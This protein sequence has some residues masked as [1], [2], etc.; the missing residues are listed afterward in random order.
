MKQYL[1]NQTQTNLQR[2]NEMQAQSQPMTKVE[3][4]IIL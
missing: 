1:L 4:L 2:Y 3:I